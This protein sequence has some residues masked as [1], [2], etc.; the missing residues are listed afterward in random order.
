MTVEGEP[1]KFP[2]WVSWWTDP[3]T[4]RSNLRQQAWLFFVMAAVIAGISAG[5]VLLRP[6]W[7]GQIVVPVAVIV[8]VVFTIGGVWILRAS[9]WIDQHQ[10]WDRITDVGERKAYEEANYPLSVRSSLLLLAAGALIG[11]LISRVWEDQVGIVPG[12]VAGAGLGFVA[13]SFLAGLREG[14]RA[15]GDEPDQ[16]KSPKAEDAP[17]GP[18]VT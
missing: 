16:T 7:M 12:A 5:Q 4:T 10:A 6:G 17:R 2:W 11:G 9:R 14:L 13:G 1:A 15:K 3:T 18:G 8:P